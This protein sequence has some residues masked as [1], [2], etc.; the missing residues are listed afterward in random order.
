[1][2]NKELLNLIK[3]AAKNE[4]SRLDLA[5]Q[6]ISLLP[7]EINQLKDLTW[8][9][10]SGNSL[11]SLPSEIGQLSEL[12]WLYLGNN[13]LESLPREIKQFQK[14][15]LLNLSENNLKGLPFEIGHLKELTEL[16][17]SSN[18]LSSLPKGILKLKNLTWL[19]LGNNRLTSLPS[20]IA[21]MENL[22]GLSLNDN[23]L[24]DL[25]PEIIQSQN[26]IE[27]D[28]TG[29]ILNPL[30]SSSESAQGF[31]KNITDPNKCKQAQEQ[32]RGQKSIHTIESVI[33]SE[34][35]AKKRTHATTIHDTISQLSHDYKST[36]DIDISTWS[37]QKGDGRFRVNALTFSEQEI[38]KLS[39]S[40]KQ[41]KI[42]LEQNELN[43]LTRDEYFDICQNC[44]ISQEEDQLKLSRYF[45]K[46]GMCLHFQ[47]NPLLRKIIFLKPD[48]CD[49]AVDKVLNNSK[50]KEKEGEF[51]QGDLDLI[52]NEEKY[53]K[54]QNE[55][56][57][58]MLEC[59]LFYPV[60]SQKNTY[61]AP[62]LL[63]SEQPEYDWNESKNLILQCVYEL[64]PKGILTH[65]I[66]GLPS[67]IDKINVWRTG[68]TIH[69]NKAFAEVIENHR[70]FK[71]EITIRFAGENKRDLLSITLY[72]LNRI[73]DSYGNLKPRM[74]VPCNCNSCQKDENP[75]L[76]EFEQL[77]NFLNHGDYKIQCHASR[78]M[79]D[80][81]TLLDEVAWL[82][83]SRSEIVKPIETK[84]VFISYAWGDDNEEPPYKR[85]EIVNKIDLAFEA[86]DI[87]LIR[88][89]RDLG[90][91]GL[92][93]SFMQL[94]GR[95]KAVIVVISDKYLR[96]QNCMFELVEIT[97]NGS[98]YDRIFPI[99]LKDAQIYDPV[100]SIDYV[101]HWEE[102]IQKLDTAMKKVGSAN[103]TGYRE[104]IDLYTRIRATI[105][106]LTDTLRNMNALSPE[107]H[108]ESGFS[109][110]IS[111][112]E[113]CL[114]S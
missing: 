114:E 85:E 65:F 28:V 62:Q 102:K 101:L 25:S 45:H 3:E 66:A 75:Y 21:Q 84:E 71:G 97:A 103:M 49:T 109:E 13:K 35:K 87:T 38:N 40:E 11:C 74:L 39:E 34:S 10:L 32:S 104:Y 69:H 93:K 110:L 112:I 22:I 17:L 16:D 52:W 6:D 26:L 67:H 63:S 41:V 89:K 2:T 27:L 91:K 8:L 19:N 106:E 23:K 57:Q 72:E 73:H 77:R 56:L 105:A 61:I 42:A 29:N 60:T 12:T 4:W 81:G 31:N 48:W 43:Y 37:F 9:D 108:T 64:M 99:V 78:Q 113:K 36:N 30:K 95:G 111:A 58:I 83:K 7:P 50:V 92:I 20:D 44:G 33:S 82:G 51:T 54:V 80:I 1:M 90:F 76:Y 5:G 14:L 86:T 100:E 24:T 53:G 59:G 79:V 94:I 88:D 70:K 96:S 18:K 55:L 15:S 107:M 47:N 46:I 68:I 98:F